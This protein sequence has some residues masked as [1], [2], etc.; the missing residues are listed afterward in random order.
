MS[1]T[2]SKLCS[3]STGTVST[4]L[5]RIQY[6]ISG[7]DRHKRAQSHRDCVSQQ[8]AWGPSPSP[9]HLQRQ[10]ACPR[11][12][13]SRLTSTCS[14]GIRCH[15]PAEADAR[16]PCAGPCSTFIPHRLHTIAVASPAPSWNMTISGFAEKGDKDVREGLAS[17]AIVT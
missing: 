16:T 7:M 2:P 4:W 14:R 9:R 8:P 17:C 10:S 12:T 13:R 6:T 5:A 11:S 3:T 15:T 1:A